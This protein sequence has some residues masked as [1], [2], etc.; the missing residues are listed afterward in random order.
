MVERCHNVGASDFPRYGGR[1]I[2]VCE[3]WRLYFVAFLS[4]MGERPQGMTLDRIDVNGPYAPGNCR[5]ATPGEQAANRRTNVL[6]EHQGRTQSIAAW[7][8]ETGIEKSTIRFRLVK[9]WTVERALTDPPMSRG[10]RGLL[11][12]AARGVI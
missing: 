9:G 11:G 10:A 7:S 1:G 6:V 5:W 2:R 3:R 4:D 12:L 8:R